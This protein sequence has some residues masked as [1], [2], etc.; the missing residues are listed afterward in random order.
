[1]QGLDGQPHAG[2][3][4]PWGQVFDCLHEEPAGMGAGVATTAAAV[5]NDH[6]AVQGSRPLDRFDGVGHAFVERAAVT[7]GKTAGP[8]H[9]RRADSKPTKQPPLLRHPEIGQLVSPHGE[10]IEA[11]GGE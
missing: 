5:E 1:M 6:L 3:H 2:P 10:G 7:A 8:L 4:G 9:A 11:M